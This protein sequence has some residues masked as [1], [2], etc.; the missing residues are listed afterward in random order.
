MCNKPGENGIPD[1][2]YRGSGDTIIISTPAEKKEIIQEAEFKIPDNFARETIDFQ[3]NPDI[4]YYRFSHFVKNESKKLFYEAWRKEKEVKM[5]LAQTDSLRKAYANA[6]VELKEVVSAQI[7]KA[8]ERS[9]ALNEEIPVEYE[10]A[11]DEENRYWQSA[12]AD[13]KTKF[14]E[15]IRLFKDSIRQIAN[16]QIEQLNTKK[17]PDTITFYNEAQK[18][19][20]KTNAP[21]EITYKILIGSFKGKIPTNTLNSIKKLSLLRKVE[22]Y[23]DEEGI[24]IYTTGSLKNYQEAVIMQN[25]VRQEGIK[26]AT[27]A[28]YQ[29]GT[30]IP[31]DKARK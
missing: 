11:R 15:K 14:Q 23:K 22:K 29:H 25:Q 9:I 2:T 26:S 6:S 24:T 5:L 1:Q 20:T 30:K 12:S 28:A 13:E 8:E 19:I 31:V 16:L 7:L 10:K 17:L 21:S 27:I 18:T 3:V 4:S